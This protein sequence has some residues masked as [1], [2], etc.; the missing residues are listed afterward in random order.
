MYA[1]PVLSLADSWGDSK[2]EERRLDDVK[3]ENRRLEK[4]HDEL[5]KSSDK[6]TAGAA[7]AR[8]ATGGL[9]RSPVPSTGDGTGTGAVPGAESGAADSASIEPGATVEAAPAPT[10][11]AGGTAEGGGGGSGA[12]NTGAVSG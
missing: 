11:G 5:S 8:V 10:P 7:G 6:S 2:A 4:R 12:T 1:R 3:R 9:E